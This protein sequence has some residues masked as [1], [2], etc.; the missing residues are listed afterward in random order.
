MAK[1]A[2]RAGKG[3]RLAGKAASRCGE[4]RRLAAIAAS[5]QDGTMPFQALH[6][7]VVA[8]PGRRPQPVVVTD[9]SLR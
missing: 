8:N 3:S 9:S 5:V 7:I 2:S 4:H 6:Q 1:T